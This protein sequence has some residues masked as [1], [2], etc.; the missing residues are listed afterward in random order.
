[1]RDTTPDRSLRLRS[2][3]VGR[4]RRA[5]VAAMALL[6]GGLVVA[7]APTAS[8]AQATGNDV[9]PWSNGWSWTYQ[10]SFHYVGDGTDATINE[11]VT[12]TVAG[13]TTFGGQDAY[14][15]NISGSI[16]GGG[17]HTSA[18]GGVD[19]RDFSGSVSGSRIVRKSDLALLRE[20]QHQDLNATAK[21]GIISVG[22][23]AEVD[24]EMTPSPAWRT[25]D[26]PLNDGDT[27][28]NDENIAYDGGFSY[29]SSL[30]S[31]SS[32][33]NG[34]FDFN[35]ASTVDNQN[36][37]VPA[38]TFSTNKIHAQASTPDGTA[39]DDIWW[40]DA[41]KNDVK[42]HMV[43]PLDGAT[44]TIDR[45]LS[46]SS[47]PTPG[48]T[49]TATATPSLTC[50]GGEVT[51]AGT[52]GNT[53]GTAVSVYLDKSPISPGSKITANTTTGANGHYETTLTAPTQSDG[54]SKNG[55][56][57]NWGIYVSGGGA[58]EATTLVV[59][60]KDC[61]ALEYTGVTT[62]PRGT[63]AAVS[64]KL[65][66]LGGG[67]A[68]G[69]TIAFSLDGGASV[70][71]TT[72]SSGVATANLPTG[73]TARDTTVR[74]TFAGSSTI[75]AA[76]DSAA[77]AVGKA[78]T[79]TSVSPSE[80]SIETTDDVTFTA[81]V[82]SAQSGA[83][84][85]AGT[86]QFTVDGTSFGAAVPLSGGSATSAAFSTNDVGEHTVQAVYSGNGDFNG[87]TSSEAIFEVTPPRAPSSTSASVSPSTSVFGESVTLSAD[88]EASGGGATPTGDVTFK[89]G[90]TSIGTATLDASGH[91][92]LDTSSL[93]VGTH[94]VV[95]V[96][97]GDDTYKSSSSTPQTATVN[98]ASVAVDLQS[99]K[100]PTVTGEA[101]D[102]SAS[103]GPVAPGSGTPS[104]TV[105]LQ[106]DGNDVGSPV[107]LSAGVASFEPVSSLHAGART[108]K[109]VYSGD[110]GFQGG[111]DSITQDVEKADTA[112][113]VITSPTTSN[114]GSPI[115]ITASVVAGAPGSGTP[116]GNV[117][118]TSDGDG[119]GGAALDDDGQASIS[120]DTLPPGDHEIKATY[121][122][123][124]DYK[125]SASEP[126]THSVI[127]G[128][129]VVETSVDLTSSENP[130][131]YG[132]LISF[133]AHVS[134]DD[135]T[136]PT[137]AVRFSVDG[138][139]IGGPVALDGDGDA[140]STQLAAPAPGDHTVIATYLPDAGYAGNG[141]MI[142]QTVNDAP[143]ELTL[144][145]SDADS[146]YGE[147][148]HVTAHVESGQA[149]TGAPTGFVQF[150]VDGVHA[151]DAVEID[152]G[153][154]VSPDI[155]DLAPGDHTITALYSGDAFFSSASTQL[156]QHVNKVGTT[157][158]LAVSPVS[159]TYGDPIEMTATVTPAVTSSGAPVGT[160]DFKDGSTTLATVAL[161]GSGSTATAQVTRSDLGAGEHSI[162]A[163]YSG[164]PVFEESSS[165]A[166]DISIAK[167]PTDMDA[168]PAVV[169]LFPLG[170]PLGQL[171][172]TVD[173]AIGPVAGV[174]VEFT[175]GNKTVGTSTTDIHGVA[176]LNA[177]S[178]LLALI[179]HNGYNAT[180]GG[181]ANFE[182]SSA[183]G[184]ILR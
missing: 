115:M 141:A 9:V 39:V 159:S 37:T 107:E 29:D 117:T 172:V 116:G 134:A 145:S 71:G 44:L 174:P 54:L 171:E 154:A 89:R 23:D 158:A 180:F 137:G 38:G 102:F 165:G 153:T 88:V 49:M 52:V 60:P 184:G 77:F 126:V 50:A 48:A 176:R 32:P 42:E 143:V 178:Q 40:S 79:V 142:T 35:G 136:V 92:T 68:A 110:A 179:L 69:K 73:N 119:I 105:Q 67:S 18:A 94:S 118:F 84:T 182:G 6:A 99:S 85:P 140:T 100:S 36:V 63:N 120:V 173:S 113:T 124:S 168:E 151:G 122:G 17:G 149:G 183:H 4:T 111:S 25:R 24:L 56:R 3:G 2:R 31:G 16:T 123:S 51:V 169:K 87:S 135:D 129:A 93:P 146:E 78:D 20:T 130:T 61:T 8:A 80:P 104:G 70:N 133:E 11:N 28:Q 160:V 82:S 108:V 128:A 41:R 62:A 43:L 65:T 166:K 1:M 148:V 72:N 98:K 181:N 112:T 57:G 90:G 58:T 152:G 19:L 103:V 131:T 46:S 91:A 157:T 7:E 156:T 86:V 45:N 125:G 106:V 97:G 12:Y 132:T 30:A 34:S 147:A 109:A 167:R 13:S 27:W 138:T 127:E 74:A 101:V 161:T 75:E 22:V 15:L 121:A 95:A 114:E 155:D 47:T 150:S 59:T 66:N 81:D 33:F 26:F 76:S 10:T 55:S 96:Y 162:K 83:G 53:S 164:S 139:N 170:L 163:V 144:E 64:A 177:S 14:Q 5:F 21:K 175:I